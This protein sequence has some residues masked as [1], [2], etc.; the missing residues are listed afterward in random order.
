MVNFVHNMQCAE[1]V[2]H[3][4]VHSVGQ[5]GFESI[6]GREQG[7][8]VSLY[9]SIIHGVKFWRG[10]NESLVCFVKVGQMSHSP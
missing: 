6:G 8:C 3:L 9:V 2:V 10:M 4:L 5:C 1:I 7:V